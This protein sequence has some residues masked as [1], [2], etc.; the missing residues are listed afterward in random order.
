MSE[1]VEVTEKL[2]KVRAPWLAKVPMDDPMKADEPQFRS[3]EKVVIRD[4]VKRNAPSRL[5]KMAH[6]LPQR[7]SPVP[8]AT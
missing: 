6:I 3:T 2:E 4:L 1:L 7:L 8:D 5:M